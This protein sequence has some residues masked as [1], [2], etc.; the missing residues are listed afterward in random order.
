MSSL[1]HK[2]NQIKAYAGYRLNAKSKYGIHSPFVYDLATKV[3][4]NKSTN[5]CFKLLKQQRKCLLNNNNVLSITDLGAGSSSLNS[6]KRKIKDIANTSLT[7]TK[8]ARLLFNLT[9][10]LNPSNILELGTNLGLTTQYLAVAHKQ[11]TVHTIEGCSSL[12]SFAKQSFEKYGMTNIEALNGT[13]DE[14]LPKVL[15]KIN[16]LGLVFIDGNHQF[17]PTLQY[18]NLCLNKV[19]EH[20][21]II[22]DD[23]YWSPAMKRAWDTIKSHQSVTLSIDLFQFGM[24]FFKPKQ[25]KQHFTVKF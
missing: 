22:F 16:T 21:V 18:F 11:G 7:R 2:L 5:P 8:Y 17:N 24:I 3:F 9:K 10:F 15:S 13:F 23:I 1:Q 14:Q 4:E 25:P 6:S 12:Y 19:D 20:S